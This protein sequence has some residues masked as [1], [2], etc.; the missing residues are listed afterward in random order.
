MADTL[1]IEE[2]GNYIKFQ[3][4]SWNVPIPVF[5]SKVYIR[6]L[7]LTPGQEVYAITGPFNTEKDFQ[8][9][10]L[11]DLNDQPFTA[12]GF[13]AFYE[14][15]TGFNPVAGGRATT[16]NPTVNDDE[17][18]GYVV[19][20]W[21]LNKLTRQLFRA[22]DVTATK[23]IWDRVNSEIDMNFAFSDTPV[24]TTATGSSWD[25]LLTLTTSSELGENAT[26][27]VLFNSAANN[28]N[29][30]KTISCRILI[31]GV[32]QPDSVR[33]I[34]QGVGGFD[35]IFSSLTCKDNVPAGTEIK[36]QWQVDS[37][38]GT[39]NGRTLQILGIPNSIRRS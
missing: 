6:P 25:D 33:V 10:E 3:L 18:K 39:A 20:A 29:N 7:N 17:T 31:N 2:S 9:N 23:A 37:N 24:T 30:N 27:V 5:K 28:S 19:G 1:R 4:S 11:R 26:Y 8:L 14:T 34:R 16:V 22:V 13:E 36:V 12:E 32:V 15:K 38:I 21:W 35:Q